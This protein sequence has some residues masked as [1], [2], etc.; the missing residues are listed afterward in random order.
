MQVKPECSG[1]NQEADALKNFTV[2]SL[3]HEALDFFKEME[4]STGKA[5][6]AS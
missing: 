3:I 4:N 2:F 5:T 1:C 6:A